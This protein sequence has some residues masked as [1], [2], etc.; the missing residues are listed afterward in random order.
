M[1]SLGSLNLKLSRVKVYLCA[2][3]NHEFE[4]LGMYTILL[5]HVWEYLLI[6]NPSF[7]VVRDW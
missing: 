7:G 6:E 5:I 2:I 4:F 3:I 1:R